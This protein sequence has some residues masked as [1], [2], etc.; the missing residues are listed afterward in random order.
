MRIQRITR[1]SLAAVV[2]TGVML[3]G[4]SRGKNVANAKPSVEE[5]IDG[6]YSEDIVVAE[7]C[8]LKLV[9]HWSAPPDGVKSKNW[10]SPHTHALALTHTRLYL[11]YSQLGR[12]NDA[13]TQRELVLKEYPN[14]DKGETWAAFLKAVQDLD[15]N[16]KVKWKQANK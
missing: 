7:S 4:C 12:T 14:K 16:G 8:L 5:L 11:L 9:D 13:A 10:T 3:A 6:Y 15:G 1:F 2:A